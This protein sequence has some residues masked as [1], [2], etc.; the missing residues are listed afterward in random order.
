MGEYK[1]IKMVNA[2]VFTCNREEDIVTSAM[3]YNPIGVIT[4]VTWHHLFG[5]HIVGT[6][7]LPIGVR[8]LV[9]TK[10]ASRIPDILGTNG[11]LLGTQ[12]LVSTNYHT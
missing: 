12:H 1:T 5:E 3:W 10:W 8:Y 11:L 2:W 7:S 9:N 4:C 6:N